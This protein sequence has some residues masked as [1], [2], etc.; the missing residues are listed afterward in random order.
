M[1]FVEEYELKSYPVAH[2]T[3]PLEPTAISDIK[4]E[5]QARLTDQT[6]ILHSWRGHQCTKSSNTDF[7]ISSRNI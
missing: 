3:Y 4:S 5:I 1:Y 2:D 7:R 6:E